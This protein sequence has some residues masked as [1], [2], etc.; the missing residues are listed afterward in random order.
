MSSGCP[1]HARAFHKT[2][3][4]RRPCGRRPGVSSDDDTGT[5]R[6]PPA[7]PAAMP[8]P[9]RF[10]LG[11]NSIILQGAGCRKDNSIPILCADSHTA[12]TGFRKKQGRKNEKL[13][14][15]S[16]HSAGVRYDPTAIRKLIPI[17]RCSFPYQSLRRIPE[18]PVSGG[19]SCRPGAG[20]YGPSC[21]SSRF[22]RSGFSFHI[23]WSL[24]R[25]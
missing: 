1:I 8:I 2:D 11:I 6:Q 10:F 14:R 15:G 3:H 18:F 4:R 23:R 21:R 20:T 13:P 17:S 19:Q 12:G 9:C 5:G 25:R 24:P 22:H 16:Y 7:F